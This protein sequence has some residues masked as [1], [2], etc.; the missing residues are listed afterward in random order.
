M[1]TFLALTGFFTNELGTYM[2]SAQQGDICG[3]NE[4]ENLPVMHARRYLQPQQNS[5]SIE[6]RSIRF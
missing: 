1:D 4:L 2:L 6:Y 3:V 5:L